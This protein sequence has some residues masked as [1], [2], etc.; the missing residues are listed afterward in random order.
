VEQFPA[1]IT[2]LDPNR[3]IDDKANLYIDAFI[4]YRTRLFSAMVAASFQLNARNITEDG[5][6]Q[7]INAYPDGSPRAFQIVDRR[8]FIFRASFDPLRT[9]AI[10]VAHES[11]E[12]VGGGSPT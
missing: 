5:R 2:A 12:R 8:P 1:I 11:H 4:N 3:P 6:L 10:G 9:D 7:R